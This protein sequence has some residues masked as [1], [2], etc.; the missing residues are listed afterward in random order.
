MA[1]AEIFLLATSFPTAI[2]RG[3]ER[4]HIFGESV[5]RKKGS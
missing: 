5:D 1:P 3:T 4:N 2:S